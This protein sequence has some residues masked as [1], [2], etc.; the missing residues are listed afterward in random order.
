M[1]E[2]K[3]LSVDLLMVCQSFTVDSRRRTILDS[4]AQIE[5]P[6]GG[7]GHFVLESVLQQSYT[8]P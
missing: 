6:Q 2:L 8:L 5:V 3:S 7:Q 4:S 1:C